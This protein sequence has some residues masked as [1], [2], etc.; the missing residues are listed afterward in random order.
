MKKSFKDFELS[1]ALS[2]ENLHYLEKIEFESSDNSFIADL[3]PVS[4]NSKAYPVEDVMLDFSNDSQSQ[5]PLNEW[6]DILRKVGHR[7]ADLNPLNPTQKN[8][9]TKCIEDYGL[10][11]NGQPSDDLLESYCGKLSNK[12]SEGCPFALNP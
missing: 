7:Y 1:S 12:S 6:Q 9:I 11:A 3:P 2:A 8:D 10:S 4:S 5:S